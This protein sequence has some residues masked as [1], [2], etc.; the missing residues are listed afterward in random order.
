M[1]ERESV[2]RNYFLRARKKMS[3]CTGGLDRDFWAERLKEIWY[4]FDA[5]LGLKFQGSRMKFS[6]EYQ[7]KFENWTKTTQFKESLNR[8]CE[9]SPVR[10]E[11][12]VRPRAD[13]SINDSNNLFEIIQMS[14]RVR[15]NLFHGGKDLESDKQHAVRN[16]ELT[17]HS[18]K[19]TYE[20]LEKVVINEGIV[21]R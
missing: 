7:R 5:L 16:R 8:L 4:S 10:D 2:C 11:N 3:E 14:Y 13:R 6:D 20:I 1:S 19:V 12:P 18:S 17:E 9:L 15:S 21:K